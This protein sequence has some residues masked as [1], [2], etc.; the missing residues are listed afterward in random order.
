MTNAKRAWAGL[1][2]GAAGGL[3][4]A[5]VMNRLSSLWGTIYKSLAK[6]KALVDNLGLE[7]KTLKPREMLRRPSPDTYL[8]RLYHR[9]K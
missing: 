3:A 2:A 4:G 1:V 9:K 7:M 6:R 8:G 5:F